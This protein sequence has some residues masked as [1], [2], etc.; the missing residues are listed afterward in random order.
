MSS[1]KMILLAGI[2]TILMGCQTA[3]AMPLMPAKPAISPP[4][5]ID[6][7]ICFTED[8]AIRLGQYILD[9]ESGYR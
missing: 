1:L 2:V 8:S 9:L 7:L 3:P 4:K 6:G 5:E